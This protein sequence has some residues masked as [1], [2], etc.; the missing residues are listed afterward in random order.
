MNGYFPKPK[1]LGVY[2]QVEIDWSNYPTKADLKDATGIYTSYFAKMT[3]LANLESDVGILYVDKE[4]K[5]I[6]KFKQFE[7]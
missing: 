4:K 6:K 2:V 5:C 7:K 3:D 1:S